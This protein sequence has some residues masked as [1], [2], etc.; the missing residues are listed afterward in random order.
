VTLE[1]VAIGLTLLVHVLGAFVLVWALLD[2]EKIDW[3]A[4]LF[5]RD[6]DGGGGGG[7]FEP[8]LD[9][10]G[11]DGGGMTAPAPLPDAAPSPVRLREPGRIGEQYPRPAR[12]PA[13]APERTPAAPREPAGS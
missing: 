1:V 11:G 4:T 12:R 8:P 10:G 5:P 7:G 6:D 3:R 13:H 9:D 2:G